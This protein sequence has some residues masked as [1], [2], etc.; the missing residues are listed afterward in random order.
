MVYSWI[1][2]RQSSS[3][4]SLHLLWRWYADT[5]P[6]GA[7]SLLIW[8]LLLK[9]YPQGTHDVGAWFGGLDATTFVDN[10]LGWYP[11]WLGW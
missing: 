4:S 3:T 7:S 8:Y 1:A 11:T 5:V 9:S 6:Q 10:L 2:L